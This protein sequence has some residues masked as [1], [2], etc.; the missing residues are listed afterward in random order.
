MLSAERGL[1][2]ASHSSSDARNKTSSIPDIHF[3]IL[4]KTGGEQD[5]VE[6]RKQFRQ[7]YGGYLDSYTRERFARA[8][9]HDN[10]ET[11]SD[12]DDEDIKLVDP[13]GEMEQFKMVSEPVSAESRNLLR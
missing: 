9:G 4:H 13:E 2:T 11:L 12:L 8:I 1:I 5:Y 3:S 10:F 7:D 6:A